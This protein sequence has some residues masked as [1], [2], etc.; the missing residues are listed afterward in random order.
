MKN[1]V[2]FEL[3]DFDSIPISLNKLIKLFKNTTKNFVFESKK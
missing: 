2:D 3:L 1:R